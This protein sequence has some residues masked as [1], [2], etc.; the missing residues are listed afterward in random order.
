MSFSET[1][2]TND[3]FTYIN[4]ELDVYKRFMDIS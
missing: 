1:C 2:D 4:K 3:P